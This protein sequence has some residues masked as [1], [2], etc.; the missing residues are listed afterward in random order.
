MCK[1]ITSIEV[2][3]TSL[4]NIFFSM[5]FMKSVGY[6]RYDFSC[7]ATGRRNVF[8][9]TEQLSV[10]FVNLLVGGVFVSR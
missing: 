3:I 9:L 8:Y 2:S 1:L 5:T 6:L 4:G 7:N 10:F